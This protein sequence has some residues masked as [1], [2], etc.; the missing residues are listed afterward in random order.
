KGVDKVAK[1]APEV[2]QILTEEQK[3]IFAS[4]S[5]CLVP[6]KDFKDPVRAGQAAGGEKQIDLLRGARAITAERWPQAKAR[7]LD[8]LKNGLFMRTAGITEETLKTA[9][10]KA[11]E[12][13]EKVRG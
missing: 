8:T 11:G 10:E 5:C 9:R 1:L 12:L 7:L 13:Y 6:P 3:N 2:D 4:F